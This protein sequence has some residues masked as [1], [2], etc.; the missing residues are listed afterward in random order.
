M[1]QSLPLQD[2]KHLIPQKEP[3]TMVDTLLAFSST[4]IVS[5]LKILKSNLFTDNEAFL[6]PGIIENMA[7]TVALHTGYDFFLKGEKAPLGYIGAI[8][9]AEV[10]K[11]PKIEETITTEAKI[12]H[13]FMGVSL[14]EATVWDSNKTLIAKAEMKTVIVSDE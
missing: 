13:E 9:K 12:L 11:L 14:V 2:I 6:E 4:D 1:S 3:F 5:S 7:Q 10:F 8:K